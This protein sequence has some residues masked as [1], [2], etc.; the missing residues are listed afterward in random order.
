[1]LH[2]DRE[3][4]LR[5]KARRIKSSCFGRVGNVGSQGW[6]WNRTLF[7]RFVEVVDPLISVHIKLVSI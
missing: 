7:I 1:M 5:E 2:K 4:T 6:R 3:Y